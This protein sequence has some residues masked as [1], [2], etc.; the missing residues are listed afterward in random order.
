MAGN[1]GVLVAVGL[2]VVALFQPGG[3]AVVE[4]IEREDLASADLG[5]ELALD[6]PEET[7]DESARG[8][9]VRGP[10]QQ[11]DVEPVAG[12]CSRRSKPP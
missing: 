10:V 5:L 1:V 7:L 2:L 12:G 6:R 9:V 3:Q 4:P 11:V 8:G